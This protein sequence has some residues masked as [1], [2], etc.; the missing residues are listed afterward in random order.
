MSRRKF[1]TANII[2]FVL[3]PAYTWVKHTHSH[4]HGSKTHPNP[5]VLYVHAQIAQYFL[6]VLCLL[7][8][9]FVC[10]KCKRT[11]ES[12]QLNDRNE[13]RGNKIRRAVQHTNIRAAIAKLLEKK[14]ARRGVERYVTFVNFFFIV[15]CKTCDWLT[16]SQLLQIYTTSARSL[17]TRMIYKAFHFISFFSASSLQSVCIIFHF[18]FLSVVEFIFKFI[19]FRIFL[20]QFLV[21]FL[22]LSSLS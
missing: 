16:D 11:D 9:L 18:Y 15:T 4:G 5:Y 19:P 20:S 10:Y 6:C 14:T 12:T 1:G 21:F 22:S 3:I 7:A 17:A 8:G 2:T 13:R